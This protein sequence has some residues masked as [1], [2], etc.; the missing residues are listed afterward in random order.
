LT[1]FPFP[2]LDDDVESAWLELTIRHETTPAVSG[3]R[4]G[5]VVIGVGQ[6]SDPLVE[7]RSRGTLREVEPLI[8]GVNLAHPLI[9]S[10]LEATDQDGHPLTGGARDAVDGWE[11]IAFPEESLRLL[12]EG[13]ARLD[14]EA[15]KSISNLTDWEPRDGQSWMVFAV[16]RSRFSALPSFGAPLRIIAFNEPD[17][18]EE[19]ARLKER[20]LRHGY[21]E[22]LESAL[23]EMRARERATNEVR[24][25]LEMIILGTTAQLVESLRNALYI[26]PLRTV[27]PRGYLYERAGRTMSWANGLAAWDRLLADRASLVEDTNRWLER[28]DAGCRVVVHEFVDW[29]AGQESKGYVDERVRRLMLDTGAGAYVLPSEVGAGISQLIPVVVATLEGSAGLSMIEQPEIHVHPRL[30]VG[31]GDLFIEAATRDG[32]RRTMLVETHGEHLILRLLRRIRETTEKELPE[33]APAFSSDNL[34]V[35]Y[36]ESHPDGVRI[37]RLRVD[38]NGEF[39]DRWPKGFFEERARELF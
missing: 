1:D 28:L 17:D 18:P 22:A 10:E 25:F 6:T 7:L 4:I 13:R 32:A 36:V 19:E 3:P 30:Q 12:T 27:P 16:S 20:T 2:N 8:V 33:G 26:G 31:L 38:E 21:T 15:A 23:H 34:S 35:V 29:S 9:A 37:R 11:R 5:R 24:T 39:T 14:E